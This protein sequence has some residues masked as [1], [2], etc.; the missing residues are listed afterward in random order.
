MEIAGKRE[1]DGRT[2]K[3]RERE[4]V[5]MY[6]TIL[7][8]VCVYGER[9]SVCVGGVLLAKTERPASNPQTEMA[10]PPVFV[11]SSRLPPQ[12]VLRST[13]AATVD[14]QP[15]SAHRNLA[16]PYLTEVNGRYTA[17]IYICAF[18]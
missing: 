8:N 9:K 17:D 5:W 12:S 16:A 2:E 14:D 3:E 4:C 13:R 6:H 1:V 11:L 15:Q 10:P 18:F 7:R